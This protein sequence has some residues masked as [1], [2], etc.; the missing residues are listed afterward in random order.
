MHIRDASGTLS[1]LELSIS[2]IYLR[3]ESCLMGGAIVFGVM[4]LMMHYSYSYLLVVVRY[5]Y[6]TSRRPGETQNI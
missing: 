3:F 6:Q 4:K 5:E 2:I 1:H